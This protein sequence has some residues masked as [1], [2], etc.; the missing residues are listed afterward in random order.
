MH[1]DFIKDRFKESKNQE[2]IIWN[3]TVYDYNF[4]LSRYD[5]WLKFLQENVKTGSVVAVRADYNPDS[6]SLMLALIENE[7][8]FVPFS[9][10]N[11]DIDEKL[12]SAQVEYYIKFDKNG[13]FDFIKI[14]IIANHELILE[15]RKRKNP[16]VIVFSSGSTGKPK[17][18]LHDY[19]YLLNKFKIKRETLRTITFLLFDHWGGINTLLYILSNTGVIGVPS[20][21]S[22]E[23]V[24]EFIEKYKIELLPTTPTFINLILISKAYLKFDISSLKVMSYG[25]EMMPESTLKAFN[26]LFPD[27]TLKQTYGLTELGVM[28]TKSESNDSLWVKVGGEDYKTKVV[29]NILYIKAKTSI[30]GYLNASSPFDEEGWYNTGDKVEQKGE[31]LRFLGRES[32]IINVGG[33]KVFPAEVESVLMQ[34]DNINEASVYGTTNPIMGNVVAAKLILEKEEPL[35]KLKNKIRKYCKDKLESFKIPVHIEIVRE[36]N[37]SD[38]F[39]KVRN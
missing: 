35:N 33:Q 25:T 21:R 32:D 7:N 1:I 22:A 18:A 27:I 4:L 15:L 39:K 37:V 6:I 19:T 3:N 29:D 30:L 20:I 28:R 31:Y 8:I 24:C 38:R 23:E 12:E 17:A 11:K 10:A 34:I 9:F 14:G 36:T 5:F 2:A 26:K 16:G 13:K